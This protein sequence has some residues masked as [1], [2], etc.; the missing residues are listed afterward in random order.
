MAWVPAA[1]GEGRILFT[2]LD[3][4]RRVDPTSPT[5]DPAAERFLLELL[6]DGIARSRE[7]RRP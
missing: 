7:P 1:S 5:Y 2:Q 4:Q 3:L 6:G